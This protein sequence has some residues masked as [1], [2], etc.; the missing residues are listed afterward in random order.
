MFRINGHRGKSSIFI[1][2]KLVTMLAKISLFRIKG[3]VQPSR[4]SNL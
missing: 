4:L 2:I 1:F 3:Q